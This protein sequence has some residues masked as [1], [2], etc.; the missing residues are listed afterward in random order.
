M[1]KL[2]D[3]HGRIIHNTTK[4]KWISYITEDYVNDNYFVGLPPRYKNHI[5]SV[6]NS[7]CVELNTSN[8]NIE[9][10]YLYLRTIIHNSYLEVTNDRLN[11]YKNKVD[12]TFKVLKELL[13]E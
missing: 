7:L 10:A 9:N 11:A 13:N 5:S 6:A 8:Y 3:V 2:E 4:D 1:N 12:K